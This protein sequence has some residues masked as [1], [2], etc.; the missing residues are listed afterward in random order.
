MSELLKGNPNTMHINVTTSEVGGSY[1]SEN[2]IS[3][4]DIVMPNLYPFWQV[5]SMMQAR[6]HEF[7]F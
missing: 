4:V 7:I 3:V 6:L 1:Y 5:F 2:L